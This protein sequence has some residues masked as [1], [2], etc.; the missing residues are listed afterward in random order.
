MARL[1]PVKF[2]GVAGALQAGYHRLL[3]DAQGGGG[4]SGGHALIVVQK[5]HLQ[6]AAGQLHHQHG[7]LPLLVRA[8]G[9]LRQARGIHTPV[10][11]AEPS[12]AAHVLADVDGNAHQPGFLA[13]FASKAVQR[14]VR[15]EKGFLCRVLRQGGVLHN[16]SAHA[17]DRQLI[18]LHQM[19]QFLVAAVRALDS[20]HSISSFRMIRRA[21]R[22]A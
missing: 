22:P 4:F 6:Q 18:A 5:H 20:V 3:G 16:G 14:P 9:G 2:A 13:V 8:G 21:I 7:K 15:T 11:E 19:D 1:L 10:D 17:F 12:A